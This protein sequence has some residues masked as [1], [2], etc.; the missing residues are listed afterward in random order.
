MGFFTPGTTLLSALDLCEDCDIPVSTRIIVTPSCNEWVQTEN[1]IKI[2]TLKTK[3]RKGKSQT[4]R[5]HI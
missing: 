1:R 4:F 3:Q 5:E 2:C